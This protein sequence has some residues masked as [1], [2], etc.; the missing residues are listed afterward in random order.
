MEM[1]GD[2]LFWDKE[3]SQEVETRSTGPDDPEAFYGKVSF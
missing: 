3:K 1:K 2:K